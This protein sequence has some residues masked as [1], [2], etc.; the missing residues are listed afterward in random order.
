MPAGSLQCPPSFRQLHAVVGPTQQYAPARTCT[1]RLCATVRLQ[2]LRRCQ[3]P[4]NLMIEETFVSATIACHVVLLPPTS[5]ACIAVTCKQAQSPPRGQ[6]PSHS[7]LAIELTTIARVAH[8]KAGMEGTSFRCVAR[9]TEVCAHLAR[10]TAP[11]MLTGKK[12]LKGKLPLSSSEQW[13]DQDMN[14]PDDHP[15]SVALLL[16]PNF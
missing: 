14:N 7:L 10:S 9:L 2:A 16:E 12:M 11:C 4:E 5:P 6:S 1:A 3:N 15:R 13:T 8:L